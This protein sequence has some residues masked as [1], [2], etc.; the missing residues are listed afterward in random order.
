MGLYHS[1]EGGEDTI[2]KNGHRKNK[3]EKPVD[4]PLPA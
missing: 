2:K 1:E 3:I 4:K